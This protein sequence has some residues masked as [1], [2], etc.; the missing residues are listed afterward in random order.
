MDQLQMVWNGLAAFGLVLIVIIEYWLTSGSI[1]ALLDSSLINSAHQ[2][3][4]YI[5]QSSSF[6]SISMKKL[7]DV[8]PRNWEIKAI[9][10]INLQALQTL[11]LSELSLGLT[12]EKPRISLNKYISILLKW[13]EHQPKQH[14]FHSISKTQ[15]WLIYLLL[16]IILLFLLKSVELPLFII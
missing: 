11:Y 4:Y 10:L 15:H 14:I 9:T 5:E 8:C 13:S 1:V 3:S 12:T 6:D 7:H 2:F 16:K